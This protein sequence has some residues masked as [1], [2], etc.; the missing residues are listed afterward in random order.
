MKRKMLKRMMKRMM[1]KTH[2]GKLLQ[3][4]VGNMKLLRVLDGV[5]RN[6]MK[7]ISIQKLGSY[8]FPVKMLMMYVN[9]LKN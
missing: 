5:V 4:I 1:K 8:K 3:K 6:T 2:N 9:G 7:E